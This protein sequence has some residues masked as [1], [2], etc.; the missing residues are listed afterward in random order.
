M[1]NNKKLKQRL[2][3]ICNGAGMEWMEDDKY[4]EC[5]DGQ[6]EGVSLAIQA[7]ERAFGLGQSSLVR[8]PWMLT[9]FDNINDLVS[10]VKDAIENDKQNEAA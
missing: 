1:K 3:D 10:L 5:P 6:L 9:K 7:I 8:K 4:F 2:L